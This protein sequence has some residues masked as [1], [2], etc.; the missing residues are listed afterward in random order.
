MFGEHLL[1]K[2]FFLCGIRRQALCFVFKETKGTQA[3][4]ETSQEL[5]KTL[6]PHLIM[7]DRIQDYKYASIFI[8]Y[9][10]TIKKPSL[11]LN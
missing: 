2:A 7:V 9:H 8:N 5:W 10:K 1:T 11:F 6:L 3:S 4:E